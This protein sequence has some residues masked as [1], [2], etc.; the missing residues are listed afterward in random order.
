MR[1]KKHLLV[2]WGFAFLILALSAWGIHTTASV[3]CD[4][5]VINGCF[6][7]G[8]FAP[9][10]FGSTGGMPDPILT[11]ETAVDGK[12]SVRLGEPVAPVEQPGG[13]AWIS[14]TIYLPA[15]MQEPILTFSYRIVT[16]DIIHWASFRAKL[17]DRDGNPVALL[18]RDGYNS[19][20]NI[21]IPHNDLGWKQVWFDLSAYRGR[22]LRLYF[23]SRN[24]F[25]GALGIWTYVDGVRL[26]EA[27]HTFLPVAMRN[28]LPGATPTPTW[29][30]TATATWTPTATATVTPSLTPTATPTSTATP[31]PTPTPPLRWYVWPAATTVDLHDVALAPDGTGWA[32]GDQGVLLRFDGERWFVWPDP[33]PTTHN[34]TAVHVVSPS[35]AWIV[36]DG[37]EVLKYDGTRWQLVARAPQPLR[38]VHMTPSGEQGWAVGDQGVIL[39][40]FQGGWYEPTLTRPSTANLYAVFTVDAD[41]AWAVGEDST[42]LQYRDGMW[43]TWSAPGMEAQRSVALRDIEMVTPNDGW[44]VGDDGTLL[45]Y[46]E[47]VWYVLQS[48]LTA[49]DLRALRLPAPDV[50]WAVGS[51]GTLLTYRAGLWHLVASPTHG[52]L[53]GIDLLPSGRGWAVG[54]QGLLVRRDWPLPVP[55]LTPTPTSSPTA[56]ATRTPTPRPATPTSTATSTPTVVLTPTLSLTPTATATASLTLTPTRS[57]TS[58]PAVRDVHSG[59][60]GAA[61]TGARWK[62]EREMQS[63]GAHEGQKKRKPQVTSD[64]ASSFRQPT[65][66]SL[67]LEDSLPSAHRIPVPSDRDPGLPASRCCHL[68]AGLRL[69]SLLAELLPPLADLGIFRLPSPARALQLLGA[70]NC[71]YTRKDGRCQ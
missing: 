44:I 29:T 71:Y 33:L 52:T 36:T 66:L 47:G 58:T 16:N 23:E 61:S 53:L 31:T 37:G 49:A 20:D 63:E 6:E 56:T 67:A 35:L 17:L 3:A 59:T 41:H 51:D 48:D 24:E 62:G 22:T 55:T 21:A 68:S 43:R 25:D 46:I 5:L 19:P 39:R 50:G 64:T 7:T 1:V 57:P 30:P 40:Y 9:W 42:I 15:D 13:A 60:H 28:Y 34:L 70:S 54:R 14:Q 65:H 2:R 38:D 10:R 8:S 45:R 18:L 26:V 32:V 4:T 27:Q 12:F 11:T 69:P